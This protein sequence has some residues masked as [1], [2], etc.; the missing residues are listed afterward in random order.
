MCPGCVHGWQPWGKFAFYLFSYH[1]GAFL[2]QFPLLPP[3]RFPLT[4]CT[5]CFEA[6]LCGS[7]VFISKPETC[8]PEEGTAK[9]V[10]LGRLESSDLLPLLPHPPRIKPEDLGR[11]FR[12]SSRRS[13]YILSLLLFMS[14]IPTYSF[15]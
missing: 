1:H 7:F 2:V 4:V 15:R 11:L 14:F 13:A 5:F 8:F 9:P 12:E 10:L 3:Y 6:D